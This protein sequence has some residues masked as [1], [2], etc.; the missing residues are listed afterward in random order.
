MR[1]PGPWVT[2]WRYRIIAL[3]TAEVMLHPMGL[4]VTYVAVM[5]ILFPIIGGGN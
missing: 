2:A 4:S 3:I 5:Q 1:L